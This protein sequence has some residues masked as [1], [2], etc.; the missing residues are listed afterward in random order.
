M[1]I[2]CIF[3]KRLHV[4]L[5]S[6]LSFQYFYQRVDRGGAAEK[7]GVRVGDQ[8]IDVNGIP[9]ENITHAHAVEVLKGKKHLI[10][11]LRVGH[12]YHKIFNWIAF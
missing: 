6:N 7:N 2:L 9:F 8:I 1:G 11:T 3:D 4:S 12:S 5:L 10:L